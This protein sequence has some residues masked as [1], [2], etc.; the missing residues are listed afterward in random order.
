MVYTFE[1]RSLAI[2]RLTSERKTN[3]SPDTQK[4]EGG[5]IWGVQRQALSIQKHVHHSK[6]F[7]N[8]GLHLSKG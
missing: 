6:I 8:V 3:G 1:W 7:F 5:A 4:A 2:V